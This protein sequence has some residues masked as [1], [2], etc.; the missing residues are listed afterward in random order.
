MAE[1]TWGDK[2]ALGFRG[3]DDEHEELFEAVRGIESAMA[4]SAEPAAIGVLLDKLVA[5]TGTHFASEESTM[6]GAKYPGLALHAAEHQRLM[7]KLGAFAARH[8]QGGVAMNQ[9]T[10]T[11]LRDWLLHHIETDDSRLG[12]WL[13]EHGSD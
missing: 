7:E 2:H 4:R 10:V 12:V 9:H 3:I 8:G 11:F 13:K 6:R 1:L 5:A